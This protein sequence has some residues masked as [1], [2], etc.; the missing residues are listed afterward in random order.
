MHRIFDKTDKG[1][2]EI[3]TRKYRLAPRLRTLLLLIDGKQNTGQ[4]LQK[5]AGLDEQSIF[6]LLDGGFIQDIEEI[7]NQPLTETPPEDAVEQT[8]SAPNSPA[9][10]ADS[11]IE[12][13]P[14]FQTIQSFYTEN[15]RTTL[16]LRGYNFQTKVNEAQSI[17]DLRALQEPYIA[18]VL[19]SK[20]EAAAHEMGSRLGELFSRYDH[21]PE[22]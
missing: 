9:A 10:S 17:D 2:E 6:D 14:N 4:L 11:T 13:V 21:P 12:D 20:G 8:E 19:K 5:I 3:A 7:S 18:A 22:Q 15:I 1:R 16:G